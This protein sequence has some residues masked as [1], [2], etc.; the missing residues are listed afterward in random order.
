MLN[1][2][3]R[4]K[5]NNRLLHSARLILMK[6]KWNMHMLTVKLSMGIRVTSVAHFMACTYLWSV[7]CQ[8]HNMLRHLVSSWWR[9]QVTSQKTFPRDRPFVWGIHRW[10]PRTR[11]THAEL[12]CFFDLCLNK[13]WSKQSRRRWFETPSRLLWHQCNVVQCLYHGYVSWFPNHFVHCC[14]VIYGNIY[15]EHEIMFEYSSVTCGRTYQQH[16]I[17]C[18]WCVRFRYLTRPETL[19]FG[20]QSDIYMTQVLIKNNVYD[21]RYLKQIHVNNE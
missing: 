11:A 12:W 14:S 3:L 21:D 19:D 9:H 6:L 16:E 17:V 13:Q 15:K 4:T 5:W 18:R 1:N 10:I 8:L 20:V 2:M 7:A